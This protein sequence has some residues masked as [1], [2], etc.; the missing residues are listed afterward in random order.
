[1]AEFKQTE[2]Q[3]AIFKNDKKGNEKAPDYT[4]NAMIHGKEVRI[5]CWVKEGKKGKYFSVKIEDANTQQS[6]G[7]NRANH[8][9]NNDNP[10]DLPF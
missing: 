5:A 8:A 3:G 10:D 7:G 9:V 6:G 2:G 4:G 1:M